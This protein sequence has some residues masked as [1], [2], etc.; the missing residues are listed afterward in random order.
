MRRAQL[1][2]FGH[3]LGGVGEDNG[4][5]GVRLMVGLVLAVLFTHRRCGGDTIA[6]QALETFEDG[7]GER[8]RRGHDPF[9]RWV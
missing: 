8:R 3:L 6:E 7:S 2:G 1:D 5:R 9:L 4:I